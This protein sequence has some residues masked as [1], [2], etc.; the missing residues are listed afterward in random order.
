[1]KGKRSLAKKLALAVF[2]KLGFQ[3]P[4]TLTK[5]VPFGSIE[6]LEIFL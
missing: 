6:F 4:K 2:K 3:F 5:T 1:M